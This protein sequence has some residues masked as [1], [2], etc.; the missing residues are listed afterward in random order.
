MQPRRVGQTLEAALGPTGLR[1]LFTNP[2][3]P[4]SRCLQPDAVT[5]RHTQAFQAQGQGHAGSQTHAVTHV[6]KNSG[7]S[8]HPLSLPP[9]GP[10]HHTGPLALHSALPS[11]LPISWALCCSITHRNQGQGDRHPFP[12]VPPTRLL[13][14]SP[15]DER[16]PQL[17]HLA[18][19][20]LCTSHVQPWDQGV[21]RP[22]GRR[23]SPA[24]ALGS[25]LES[26]PP[27]SEGRGLG[28]DLRGWERGAGPQ[29]RLQQWAQPPRLLEEIRRASW[30][31]GALS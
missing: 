4:R 27:K 19:S 3:R 25:H 13:L 12:A 26:P 14:L 11:H 17:R 1:G 2:S 5:Q 20:E 29:S 21:A 9:H 15:H 6:N 16:D 31:K 22:W 8:P 28:V 7:L 30:K 23:R 18:L 10:L 24:A